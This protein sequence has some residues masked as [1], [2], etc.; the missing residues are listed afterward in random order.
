MLAFDVERPQVVEVCFQAS[1][2][3]EIP[4]TVEQVRESSLSSPSPALRTPLATIK[5]YVDALQYGNLGELTGLQMKKIGIIKARADRMAD[6]L[7]DADWAFSILDE[8]DLDFVS[9]LS[10]ELR[11]PLAIIKGYADALQYGDLGELTGLQM[12]EVRII[13]AC[14]DLMADVIDDLLDISLFEDIDLVG[15][16][17]PTPNRDDIRNMICHISSS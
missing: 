13:N 1:P 2:T 11:T 16:E 6:V 7:E 5:R 3:I 15:E 12:E 10:H 17:W 8:V 9:S 4:V 14:A